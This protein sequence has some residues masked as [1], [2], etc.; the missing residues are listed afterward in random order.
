MGVGEGGAILSRSEVNFI[1]LE[2]LE[3][4]DDKLVCVCMCGGWGA[5]VSSNFIL[6]VSCH[7]CLGLFS[8]FSLLPSL[9]SLLARSRSLEMPQTAVIGA[10]GGGGVAAANNCNYQK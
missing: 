4:N 8:S 1:L 7:N 9:H 2:L 3:S 5:I 6:A 10:H